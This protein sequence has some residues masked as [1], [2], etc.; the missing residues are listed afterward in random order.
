MNNFCR[1]HI[2][3]SVLVKIK[4]ALIENNTIMDVVGTGIYIAAE[5]WWFEGLCT[6]EHIEIRRNRIVRCGR[7]GTAARPRGCAGICVTI[8]A[9][10][11]TAATHKNIIIEDNIIDCPD[12]PH[13]VYVSNTA[14]ATVRRNRITSAAEPTVIEPVPTRK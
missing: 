5:A 12:S 2:A 11:P 14:N 10:N 8:D 3:R 4:D 6:T 7:M 13:G 1:S 9:N